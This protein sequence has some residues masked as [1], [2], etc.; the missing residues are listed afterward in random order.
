MTCIP[1]TDW[2]SISAWS[3]TNLL[4]ADEAAARQL[5]TKVGRLLQ[6]LGVAQDHRTAALQSRPGSRQEVHMR[7]VRS[8]EDA[9][10]VMEQGP[11]PGLRLG[12]QHI[13]ALRC[14]EVCRRL[15]LVVVAPWSLQTSDLPQLGTA[16][17][18]AC[19]QG[20]HSA[21]QIRE[22]GRVLQA[23][24]CMMLSRFTA[25]QHAMPY[26]GQSAGSAFCV[27]RPCA[28]LMCAYGAMAA[29]ALHIIRSCGHARG[30]TSVRLP[31]DS[32][33]GA[34]PPQGS[35]EFFRCT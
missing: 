20:A 19:W 35:A 17:G 31:P 25:Y 4:S 14:Y 32:P 9:L 1:N 18:P 34:V 21:L 12:R 29:V 26:R 24:A 16:F 6:S 15:G 13:W 27:P 22:L 5:A 28:G 30:E 10:T 3:A 2:R 8:A 7:G 33:H 11:G 23:A